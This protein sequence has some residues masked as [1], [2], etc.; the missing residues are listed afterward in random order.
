MTTYITVAD[1]DALLGATWTTEEKKPRAVLMANTWLT[2][3]HLPE[4]D[5]V[6]EDVIQAGAEV[7]REAA[8]GNLYGAKETGVTAKSV[9][10]GSVSS[11]K[12]FSESSSTISAGESFALALLAHYLG[13]G[14]VKVVRC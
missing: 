12:S 6:P 4:F 7:A 2:N 3:L 10:A 1:V 9:S 11:S 5:P 13:S 8:A 14:Q